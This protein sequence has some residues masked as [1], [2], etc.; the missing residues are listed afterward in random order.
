MQQQQGLKQHRTIPVILMLQ[1]KLMSQLVCYIWR[2]ADVNPQDEQNQEEARNKQKNALELKEYFDQ[3]YLYNKKSKPRNKI[4]EVLMT[5]D[6]K[7]YLLANE[8]ERNSFTPNDKNA[9]QLLIR[10]F[11]EHRVRNEINYL[12][13]IFERESIDMGGDIDSPYPVYQLTRDMTSFSGVIKDPSLYPRFALKYQVT[14]PP[15]P[16]LSESTVTKYELDKWINDTEEKHF[17]PEHNY[18]PVST[19]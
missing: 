11:G 8:E 14:F 13:P 7:K 5:V 6:A 16:K 3:L 4:L 1:G 18:I 9:A 2:W 12:S 19:C 15:A 17:L 10:V